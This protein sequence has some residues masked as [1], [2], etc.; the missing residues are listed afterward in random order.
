MKIFLL[1]CVA[2]L[3]LSFP[4]SLELTNTVDNLKPSPLQ[5]FTGGHKGKEPSRK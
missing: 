2:T 5:V 4:N 1:F 3:S